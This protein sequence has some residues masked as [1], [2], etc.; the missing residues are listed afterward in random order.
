MRA[1]AGVA[2]PSGW[3][4]GIA[5]ANRST[6][7]R[8]RHARADGGVVYREALLPRSRSWSGQQTGGRARCALQIRS[9]CGMPPKKQRYQALAAWPRLVAESWR[10]QLRALAAVQKCSN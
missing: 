5:S 1:D 2:E 6:G 3:H 4:F 9:S 8:E 10:I 7:D